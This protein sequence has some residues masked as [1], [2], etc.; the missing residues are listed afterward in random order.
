M[1]TL[2]GHTACAQHTM[3]YLRSASDHVLDEVT[4]ARSIDNSDVILGRFKLPESNID[5]DTTLSLSLQFVQYPGVLERT[6]THLKNV[7][8]NQV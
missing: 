2:Y 8:L 1:G 7:P 5:G 3:D 4:M 6:F